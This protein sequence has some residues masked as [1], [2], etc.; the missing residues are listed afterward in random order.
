MQR[1]IEIRK[2][3]DE[4][5]ILWEELEEQS[6]N[7]RKAY[8]K[9]MINL[10]QVVIEKSALYL[11][12]D[13][14]IDNVKDKTEVKEAEFERKIQNRRMRKYKNNQV[15]DLDA[16][17]MTTGV[18]EFLMKNT[19]IENQSIGKKHRNSVIEIDEEIKV[20]DG[21]TESNMSNNSLINF[22]KS[23]IKYEKTKLTKNTEDDNICLPIKFS[24]L[25]PEG[26]K[27]KM[28]DYNSDQASLSNDELPKSLPQKFTEVDA[29][30]LSAASRP[31]QFYKN[32][33][34]RKSIDASNG[35]PYHES[36][37]LV[38]MDFKEMQEYYREIHKASL[39]NRKNRHARNIKTRTIYDQPIKRKGNKNTKI[40]QSNQINFHDYRLEKSINLDS[41]FDPSTF[42]NNNN[43]LG[44]KTLNDINQTQGSN[45]MHFIKS[46]T[47]KS[48]KVQKYDNR[49]ISEIDKEHEHNA[50]DAQS[51]DFEEREDNNYGYLRSMS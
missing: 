14:Y 7:I 2:K 26:Y 11:K 27:N 1:E 18:D 51:Q 37:S 10:N 6:D 48:K 34:S 12:V 44:S 47:S 16:I 17:R 35:L 3:K 25:K 5:D 21:L 32:S 20:L 8:K 22:E 33:I 46:G 9:G 13:K 28:L 30:P 15:A 38:E 36:K 31:F 40:K 29:N 4:Q 43:T 49:S 41:M 42:R 23:D 24:S 39:K 19:D 50:L 45:K